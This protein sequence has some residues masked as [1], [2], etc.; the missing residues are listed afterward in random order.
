MT[1]RRAVESDLAGILKVHCGSNLSIDPDPSPGYKYAISHNT[2][3]VADEDGE[4][5]GFGLLRGTNVDS[6]YV[7]KEIR[8]RGT[9]SL[10]L[11]QL[12]NT[13]REQGQLLLHV[14]A[15]PPD[16]QD[17]ERLRGFYKHR[18]YT[19]VQILAGR[20]VDFEKIL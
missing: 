17:F 14:H 15:N 9:G 8:C 13:A 19:E 1:I 11:E 16:L 3:L 10:L 6:L 7:L 12:E 18:G 4:V 5:V 20:W 2:V